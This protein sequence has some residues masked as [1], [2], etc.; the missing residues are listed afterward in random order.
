MDRLALNYSHLVLENTMSNDSFAI[1]LRVGSGLLFAGMVACVKLAATSESPTGQIVFFRSAFALIPLVLFLVITREFPSG[2]YTKKPIGHLLRCLTGCVAMFG[3]FATLSY[4]PIAEATILTYLSPV[5][6]A[7]LAAVFL[8]ED[9]NSTR[10]MGIAL[11]VIGT[12]VLIVPQLTGEVDQNYAF[13]IGLGV[14]TAIVTAFAIIQIRNLARTENAGAI[15]FYFALVCA[16]AGLMTAPFGWTQPSM[17][18]L[19]ALIGAGLFG[20][21][22]HIAMTLSF[23]YAEASKLAPFDYLSLI[24][25]IGTGFAIFGDLPTISFYFALPF[26]LLG[27]ML[28]AFKDGFRRHLPR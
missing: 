5:L 1:A 27:A 2:L 4:L 22:A 13:G 11:G 18:S 14:F 20:G 7:I 10:W 25:A 16:I 3:S 12:L 6:V 17:P 23:K 15:A 28:V 9:V 26:I 21:F 24:W 19:L 8:K